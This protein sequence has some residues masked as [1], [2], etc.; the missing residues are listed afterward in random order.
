MYHICSYNQIVKNYY[1]QAI[2]I[3]FMYKFKLTVYTSNYQLKIILILSIGS[4]LN[5]QNPV[6]YVSLDLCCF[7]WLK[8]TARLLFPQ[9]HNI[10][11]ILT[12]TYHGKR[13]MFPALQLFTH[14][15]LLCAGQNSTRIHH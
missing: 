1:I 3:I 4:L 10:S 9:S 11:N 13:K 2:Q 14:N 8:H 15:T 5:I 12:M 6:N 7:C